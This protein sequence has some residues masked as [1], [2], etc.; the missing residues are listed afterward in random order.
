MNAVIFDFGGTLDTGGIHWYE[1]FLTVYSDLG[2]RI[3]RNIFRDA[4]SYA[5]KQMSLH[6]NRELRFTDCY[7]RK[8]SFQIQYM[9][10]QGLLP[11]I[12]E[13]ERVSFS[14][15]QNCRFEVDRH[16]DK[17]KHFLTE[18][19]HKYDLALVSNYYGNLRLICKEFEIDHYFKTIV[20]SALCG[21][22]KP[23]PQIFRIALDDLHLKPEGSFIVGDSY[24]KDIYPA[25]TLGCKTVWLKVKAWDNLGEAGGADYIIGNLKE[26][27]AILLPEIYS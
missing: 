9:K 4:F 25:R 8:I 19:T 20:D 23:D 10:D 16:L 12:E 1:K 14:I 18:L 7:A 15:A 2:I 17:H 11:Y 22:R 24:E 21:V 6:D 3:D 13:V 26:L 27:K 5:E